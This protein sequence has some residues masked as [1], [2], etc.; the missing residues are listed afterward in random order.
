MG[1]NMPCPA[2][3]N[4]ICFHKRPWLRKEGK[5]MA[6]SAEEISCTIARILTD[7]HCPAWNTNA[8]RNNLNSTG[9]DP[10]SNCCCM[11]SCLCSLRIW[12]GKDYCHIHECTKNIAAWRPQVLCCFSRQSVC[13][14]VNPVMNEY[15]AVCKDL[16]NKRHISVQKRHCR[17]SLTCSAYLQWKFDVKCSG[18]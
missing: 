13:L 7:L 5:G 18:L 14:D 2:F 15:E 8:P 16:S 1:S 12:N 3:R 6:K 9:P 11:L 17:V 4:G 10:N